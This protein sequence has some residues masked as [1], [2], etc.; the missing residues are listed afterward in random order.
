MTMLDPHT[1]MAT[2]VVNQARI[3]GREAPQ[4]RTLV[5][6]SW[7]DYIYAE[8]WQRPGLSDRA[9]YLISIAG[10]ACEGGKSALIDNYVRG[11]LKNGELSQLELREAALHLAVYSGWAN[12]VAMDDAISRVV[13]ELGLEPIAVPPIRGDA[14]DPE[15]RLVEGARNFTDLMHFPPPPP[16]VA[17]FEGGILNFVF[18]EMWRR[19]GL[20]EPSRRWITLV[21]VANS[22]AYTPIH[23]HT[24]AAMKSG[25]AT[26]E[27]M[28]E[29]VLQYA[30]HAGWPRASVMQGAVF[31]MGKLVAEGLPYS[32]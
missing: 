19:P 20:D 2:G 29:F 12:G 32:E 31:A 5:Q 14:W 22:S 15:Q 25:N 27:E 3:E 7:R 24:Y 4:P 17:Y 10:A 11:A 6:A 13:D 8:V 16:A 23:T 21:G 28:H 30:V 18:G 9:R 26:V 1:R